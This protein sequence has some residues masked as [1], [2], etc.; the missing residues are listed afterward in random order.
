MLAGERM[1]TDGVV[2]SGRSSLDVSAV[3][4]ESI[5]VEVEVGDAVLA[6]SVNGGGLLD[7]EA[8]ATADVLDA[9]AHPHELPES[10]ATFLYLDAAQ[11]GLGSRSCGI[12][13]VP[14]HALWPGTFEFTVL[15]STTDRD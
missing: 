7:V 11:H 9:A 12:D 14:E 8:T 3:T 10:E 1:A 2:R 4:G 13:V 5:P 15:L 6:G